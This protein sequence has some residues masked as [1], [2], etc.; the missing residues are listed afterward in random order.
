MQKR[1]AGARKWVIPD[2]YLPEKSTGGLLS[3]ES[4]CVVNLGGRPASLVFTAYFEDRP[5]VPRLLACCPSQRT[6]HV[7]VDSLRSLKGQS[8]P[9]GVPFALVVESS[10]PVVVQHTRLDTTQPAL[11]L[12]TTMA[13]AVRAAKSA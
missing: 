2:C 13:F 7:R 12:M 1:P 5:P 8:I 6:V 11:A 3:H 10:V 9:K 4:T